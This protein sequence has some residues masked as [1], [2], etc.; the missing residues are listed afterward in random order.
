M[1]SLVNFIPLYVV[2]PT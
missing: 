1:I 2:Y